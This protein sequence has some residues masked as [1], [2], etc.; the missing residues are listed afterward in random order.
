MI[1]GFY[2]GVSGIKT[3]S[4]G[5]DVWSNNIS[6]IN[7]VGFKASTPEFKSIF[8][9]SM[10][11]AGNNP[12]TDQVGLGAVKQA[13]ALNMSN[14]TYQNT[15]NK[16]DFAIQG[17]GF[18][19]VKDRYG[20]TYY[21]R[22]G[23]FDIDA[24]GNLVDVTGKF[25]Q[26]TMNALTPITPSQNAL[27]IYGNKNGVV[28]AYSVAENANL[29]LTD[30]N[31]QQNIKLPNFLYQP[32]KATTK[33]DIVG[34]L[35]STRINETTEITLDEN[36][37]TYTLDNTAKTLNISGVVTDS[38]NVQKF[39]ANDN[40]TIKISDDSGKFSEFRTQVDENGAFSLNDA[41][42]A[43]LDLDTAKI[44][45][46]LTTNQEIP[47]TQK[48]SSEI[49]TATG[50]K[51]LLTLSYTKKVPQGSDTTT[52]DVVATIT[53]K[54]GNEVASNTG[55]LVFGDNSTLQSTTITEVGGVAL[56]F[57]DQS[58]TNGVY[59]GLTSGAFASGT[60]LTKD[61]YDE[62][63]LKSYE[64][65]DEGTIMA[66]FNNGNAFSVAKVALYHFQNDQ[67]LAKMSE[68]V[69]AKTSNS[70]EPIFY[71]DKSGATILGAKISSN[72]LEMSNVDLGTA[73]TEIIVIQKA[74]DASSK[75][76]T[77]SDEMIQTAIQMKK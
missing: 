2:N 61:G 5:M 71:K 9:Q 36:S 32:A 69:Y 48:M 24:A 43:Y 17:D 6:N 51:N 47:N 8:Y 62:G 13:T 68:N 15:D 7:N 38:P 30:P 77:T 12:T 63:V 1:R 50:E 64:V 70:G 54:D 3:Q 28:E 67:G 37:Y 53:D 46:S 74:Y 34:N 72:R 23:A 58:T 16:F 76:I 65:V 19:G 73:L 10:V 27:S 11:S 35:N 39:R 25:V 14:G 49:F 45:A 18:F 41:R 75:S 29:A 40:I 60:Q 55:T 59:R 44:S 57:T 52:W 20:T 31:A 33:L 4:F 56:N 22:N 42:L 21:T 26:G 66:V